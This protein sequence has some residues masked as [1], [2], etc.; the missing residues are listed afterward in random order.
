M[1]AKEEMTV[2]LRRARTW[3]LAVGI[4]M[5]SVDMF[6]TY[7]VNSRLIPDYW[8]TRILIIDLVVLG[9]FVT[10]W[11]IAGSKPKLACILALVGF[12]GM[13]IAISMWANDM[14]LLFKNGPLMKILFT[15]A[16]V[17]GLKSAQ[18]AEE[19]QKQLAQVFE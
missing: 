16:L 1:D 14:S 3:I 7:S 19:L 2:E 9:Y 6:M 8:K 10:C 13:H 12:W 17:R 18:R 15:L 11:I 5:F 4:I